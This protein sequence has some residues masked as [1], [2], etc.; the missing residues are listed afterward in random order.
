MLNSM[1]SY[2]HTPHGIDLYISSKSSDDLLFRHR[3][4]QQIKYTATMASAARRQIIG[5]GAPIIESRRR[6]RLTLIV[7]GG[8]EAGTWL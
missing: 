6:R 7:G 8:G 4:L 1:L 2:N 3:K 5:G